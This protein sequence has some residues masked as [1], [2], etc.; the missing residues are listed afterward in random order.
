MGR[1]SCTHFLWFLRV[2]SV[3]VLAAVLMA[4]SFVSA[5]AAGQPRPGLDINGSQGAPGSGLAP[6]KHVPNLASLSNA[7]GFDRVVVPHLL[8]GRGPNAQA[9][10]GPA[11]PHVSAAPGVRTAEHAPG[12]L[13]SSGAAT[14]NAPV[15]AA[16]AAVSEG[17]SGQIPPDPTMAAGPLQIVV[18][19]NGRIKAFTKTGTLVPNSSMSLG[20]FFSSLSGAADGPFDPKAAFDPYI[21]RFWLMSV[22]QHE[23]TVAD[24]TNR[25]TFLIAISDTNDVTQGWTFFQMDASINGNQASGRWCDYPQLGFDSQAVYLTCNMF[26]FGNPLINIAYSKVRILLKSEFTG[27]GCCSWWDEWNFHEG[28]LNLI[29]SFTMQPAKMYGARDFD[30]EFL[31]DSH[32]TC[33]GPCSDLEVF[34]ITNAQNCC[35]GS[36]AGPTFNQTGHGVGNFPSPTGGRQ[37]GST[38]RLDTGDTRLLYAFWQNGRLFTGQNMSDNGNSSVSFFELDVAAGLGGINTVQAWQLTNAGVDY[39]YPEVDVNASGDKAMVFS[40]SSSSEF[41]SARFVTIPRTSTCVACIGPEIVLANGD[42]TYVQ[43]DPNGNRNRWGDYSG[44]AADPDGLGIWVH[45]EFASASNSWTTVVGLAF[46]AFDTDLGIA[47]V[48]ANITVNATSPSG[49]VVTYPMPTAVDEPGDN[50]APTV[51]CTPASGSTFPI[52]TTTVTCTATSA[53]DT[54]STVSRT[55]TVTVRDTDLGL[56][57]VPANITVNATS[58][59]GAVVTYAMPTAVDEAADL[60]APTVSCTPASGSTF[61]IGTTTVTCT[62]TSADDIPSTFSQSF[63]VTVNDTD[64]GITGVPANITVDATSTSGAVVTYAMP[65]AVDEAGDLVAP[66]VSCT[67]ASGSTFPIGTTTVTCTATSADDN[68]SSVSQSFTVTVNDTDL[69]IAGVPANMTVDVNSPLGAV[70]TWAMPTAI[71][72]AGDV[73]APTV[74]CTPMSGSTFPLGTTTVTCT[75]TSADD[76][77]STVSKSFTVTVVATPAGI[78]NVVDQLLAAGCIDN[79]GIANALKAKLAAAQNAIAAGNDQEAINILRAFIHE[80]QAQDSKHLLAACTINGVT[81]SP[82]AILIADAQSL[83]DSLTAAAAANP[84]GHLQGIL[85]RPI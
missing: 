26:Q 58:S 23:A 64:L 56:A 29:P 13:G 9:E 10:P 6:G 28:F 71:D 75:A 19:T 63:T 85:R 62:A 55:F 5:S 45:G 47:G 60:V 2:P 12:A 14:P 72:E 66:T 81:F 80:V 51:S 50:P 3:A 68:P 84:L 8:Q 83:I 39:Y 48:P 42:S 18:M 82:A 40:R 24:N 43:I 54:P 53:D 61:P 79:A 4:S 46:E 44:A 57:G 36:A 34:R 16:F 76:N 41:V 15:G 73:P 74:S 7:K 49:A 67:P 21:N 35:N 20:Q 1:L 11:I 59:S 52:G 27:G 38:T 22:S 78:S 37:S 69:G 25:S 17:E 30:G 33:I 70:V 32:T 31:V 77:P 65:T